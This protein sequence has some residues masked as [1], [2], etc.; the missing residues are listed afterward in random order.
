M[1]NRNRIGYIYS[2]SNS[3]DITEVRYIGKTFNAP[4]RD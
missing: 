3:K 2:L 1:E 4:K